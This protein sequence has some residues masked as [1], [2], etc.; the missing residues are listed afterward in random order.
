MIEAVFTFG[1]VIFIGI[2]AILVKL[3]RR[4]ALWLLGHALWL[5]ILVTLFALA[6]HW[7]TVTGLMAAAVAGLMCSVTTSFARWLI[8]Y[9][10][11]KKYYPGVIKVRV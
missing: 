11:G 5:D 7:G 8:G 9:T 2:A 3:P 6:I 4:T 10:R 1:L